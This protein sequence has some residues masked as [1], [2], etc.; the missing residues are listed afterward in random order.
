MSEVGCVN[1]TINCSCL[2]SATLSNFISFN[3]IIF[4]CAYFLSDDGVIYFFPSRRL[5]LE[6]L[7]YEKMIVKNN[8]DLDFYYLD[9]FNLMQTPLFSQSDGI[10]AFN[11]FYSKLNFYINKQL[12]NDNCTDISFFYDTYFLKNLNYI[13]FIFENVF[14]KDICPFI[15]FHANITGMELFD[16][17]NTFFLEIS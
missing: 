17:R 8:L 13:R 15:F 10:V 14:S 12:L 7:R 9:G 4:L 6:S 1:L 16:L 11:I 5:V 3:Q 2:D